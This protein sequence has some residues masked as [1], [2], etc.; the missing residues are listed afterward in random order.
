MS[1]FYATQRHIRACHD[2]LMI[3]DYVCISGKL[4]LYYDLATTCSFEMQVKNPGAEDQALDY[5]W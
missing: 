3:N 1:N 5:P 4:V 2:F